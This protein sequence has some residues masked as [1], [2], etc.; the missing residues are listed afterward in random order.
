MKTVK[1]PREVREIIDRLKRD[2]A[3]VGLI[4]TMGAL[5][6][7]HASLVRLA[8]SRSGFVVASIFVNPKQFGPREDRGRYPRA[9]DG[10]CRLLESLGCDLLFHPADGDLYSHADRTRVAVEGLSD[11]LCGTSRSGHFHGV[12]LVVAKLF[13]IVRPDEA[14]FGQKDAQQAVIIQRMAADLDVPVRIVLGPTI[15]E[16]DGLAMSS[17]NVYLDDSSRASAPAIYRSLRAAKER[18]EAGDRDPVAVAAGVARMMREGGFEVEYA[19]VVDGAALEAIERIEGIVLIACAGKIGGTRLIDNIALRV[20]GTKVEE[21]LL[22]F[23]EWS[24]YA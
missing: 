4:P 9:F 17:R 5:H 3:S 6:E 22:M 19:S 21:I 24:R 16:A 18:V 1:A 7:G 14:Y 20:A 13:N 8:R 11:V 23:P 12:T 10:D 2:G 15:R